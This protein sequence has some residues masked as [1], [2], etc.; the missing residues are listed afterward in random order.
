MLF[1]SGISQVLSLIALCILIKELLSIE[2]EPLH[3]IE[4]A[5]KIHS[6]YIRNTFHNLKHFFLKRDIK[7]TEQRCNLMPQSILV[8]LKAHI[9]SEA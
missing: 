4:T 5:E 6:L 2:D 1:A 3:I 9:P 8:L 7:S